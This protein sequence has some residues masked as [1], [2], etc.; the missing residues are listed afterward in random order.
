[1]AKDF[2][3]INAGKVKSAIEEATQ[4]PQETRKERKTYTE[5][6]A[7]GYINDGKTSGRKGLRLRRINMAFTPDTYDYIHTMS[8]VRGE[9][10]T[11]F[12]NKLVREHLQA[13]ADTYKKA[14]EFKNSL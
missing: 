9:S 4:E 2:K 1:M 11:D 12:V 8:R 14:I 3:G 10:M 5:Q 7:Q 13:N 6:E